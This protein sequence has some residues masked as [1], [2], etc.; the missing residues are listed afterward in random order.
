[1]RAAALGDQHGGADAVEPDAEFEPN[2]ANSIV[3]LV[4]SFPI[5]SQT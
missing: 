1:M 2:I 4:R 5:C 3:W